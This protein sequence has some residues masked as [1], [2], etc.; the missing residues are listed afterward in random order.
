MNK[1]ITARFENDMKIIIKS[2]IEEVYNIDAIVLGGSYGNGEGVWITSE[3]SDYIFPYNDYDI[4]IITDSY[5]N[6]K[7]ISSL[8]KTIAAEVDIKWIDIDILTNNELKKLNNRQMNVDLINGNKVIYGRKD[9][10]EKCKNLNYSKLP[11]RDIE[12]QYFTR[13]WTFFGSLDENISDLSKEQATFF[14][15]QMCKAIFACIDVLLI[16]KDKYI[17]SYEAKSKRIREIYPKNE[18]LVTYSRW[19]IEKRKYPIMESMK[20]VDVLIL[21]ND[22]YRLFYSSMSKAMKWR[23]KVLKSGNF[24]ILYYYLSVY[25]LSRILLNK[26]IRKSNSYRKYIDIS[27]AQNYLFHAYNFGKIKNELLIKAKD[28]LE[29]YDYKSIKDAGW[30]QLRL[31]VAKARNEI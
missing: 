18:Q 9:I 8:R 4:T 16:D 21:F 1:K 13:L 19:A 14:C 26:I 25:H 31:L 27:L 20:I 17:S 10:F 24:A 2:I 5:V 7:V 15:N 11:Y 23:W 12:K 6:P 30:N 28:I 29:K 22:V 3:N